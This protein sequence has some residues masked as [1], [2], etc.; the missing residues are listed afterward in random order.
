M[1]GFLRVARLSLVGVL[2]GSWLIGTGIHA[3][4][5]NPS[6]YV[7]YNPSEL[8]LPEADWVQP[9]LL[10]EAQRLHAH[11]PLD[12]LVV[13]RR[14]EER[15]WVLDFYQL[16]E[17]LKSPLETHRPLRSLTVSLEPEL[18]EHNYNTRVWDIAFHPTEPLIYLFVSNE[19]THSRLDEQSQLLRD[20]LRPLQVYRWRGNRPVKVAEWK[21]GGGLVNTSGRYNLHLTTDGSRLYFSNVN[22]PETRGMAAS[23]GYLNMN[24]A[25][26]PELKGDRIEFAEILRGTPAVG[27][28][29]SGIGDGFT[30]IAPGVVAFG[31][32]FGAL[33]HNPGTRRSALSFLELTNFDGA[34]SVGG[35]M[36]FPSIYGTQLNGGNLTR[37]GV[38]EGAFTDIPQRGVVSGV[39]FTGYPVVLADRGVVAFPSN[40]GILFLE[41]DDFGRI[42]EAARFLPVSGG[43][44]GILVDE[45]SGRL[46]YA[47]NEPPEET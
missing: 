9:V 46:I 7:E 31:S 5:K 40:R 47:V 15:T 11:P 35:A 6:R 20:H 28:L 42:G 13:S 27:R 38:W 8:A 24:E 37:L 21:S 30:E 22:H 10:P 36:N 3:A 14:G 29:A 44:Q 23:I 41:V 16:S 32:F 4:G 43:V 39:R 17:V 2:L 12:L 26:L 25:G 18:I 1:T 34:Y 45:E 33:I 19:N